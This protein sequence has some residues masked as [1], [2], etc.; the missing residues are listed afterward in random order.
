VKLA[1]K[2]IDKLV[3]PPRVSDPDRL[4]TAVSRK[5]VLVTG[6]S[7]GLGEA[8]A[9]NLGAAGA[10]VVLV[11][12]SA[13]KLEELAASITAGG[14]RAIAYPADLTDEGAVT[15]LTNQI[16]NDYGPPDIVI[17]NAG[18][19]IR[20]E[21]HLQ[22][23]RPHDFERTIDINYLGPIRLLLGLLPAMR[24][25]GSGHIVNISSIG[26]R[27]PPG[28]RWGTY[29][30]SKGAFDTWLRSVAP[31]L[32]A[33]GV[34]V[35]SVY[36]ALIRTRMIEPS[37]SLR[38]FPGLSPD[39]AAEVVAKAII[40]RPGTIAPWWAWPAELTSVLLRAPVDRAARLWY[41]YTDARSRRKAQR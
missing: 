22:Y 3:N 16:T 12:R 33:D 37:T 41:R 36:M 8:T 18:K 21:L 35:T 28:P 23:D 20:R 7:Y 40:E 5:T 17:S 4:R 15:D 30:A 34:D 13:D 1:T 14:G 19:S 10:T 39:E 38:K 29:Q 2:A 9:R 27:V 26:V 32:H 11:A 24:Q 31:E 25:R 6:A